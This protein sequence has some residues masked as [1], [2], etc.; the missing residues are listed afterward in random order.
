[1]RTRKEEV[2]GKIRERFL[3][4]TTRLGGAWE[5]TKGHSRGRKRKSVLYGKELGGLM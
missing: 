2:R 5:K 4:S 1:V 3:Y